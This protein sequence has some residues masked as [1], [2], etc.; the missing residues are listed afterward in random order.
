VLYRRIWSIVG[1]YSILCCDRGGTFIVPFFGFI[2]IFLFSVLFSGLGCS[3]YL[4]FIGWGFY[5]G[6][7]VFCC[8][9]VVFF[10]V[11]VFFFIFLLGVIFLFGM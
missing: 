4:E 11:F 5:S 10:V 8:I 3:S 1:K 9:V 2:H 6:F 7:F